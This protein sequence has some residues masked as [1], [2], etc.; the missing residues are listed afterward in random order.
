M[1]AGVRSASSCHLYLEATPCNLNGLFA[2]GVTT[3]RHIII[4]P[5]FGLRGA[6]LSRAIITLVV[7]PAFVAYGYN[8]SVAGGLLTL[9]AF[10]KAF[11]ELDTINTHGKKQSYNSTIQGISSR[12]A[13]FCTL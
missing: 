5:Y 11:P 6:A 9:D 4:M 12:L 3:S 13:S 10:V 2:V 7:C 8:L 1:A